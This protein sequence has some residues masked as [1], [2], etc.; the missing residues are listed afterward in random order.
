V[1]FLLIVYVIPNGIVGLIEDAMNRRAKLGG[2]APGPLQ[3]V[4]DASTASVRNILQR[5]KSHNV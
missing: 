1:C 2:S 5:R 4:L 3:R